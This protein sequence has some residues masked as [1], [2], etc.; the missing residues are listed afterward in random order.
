M[1]RSK[2]E[3]A[4]NEEAELLHEVAA[5]LHEVLF[6]F[7]SSIESKFYFSIKNHLKIIIEILYK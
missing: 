1:A 2:V 4:L 3:T 5:A 7:F 6:Y